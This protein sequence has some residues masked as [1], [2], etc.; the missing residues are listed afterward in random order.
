MEEILTHI[1]E[2]L[3]VPEFLINQ[4]NFLPENVKN[5]LITILLFPVSKTLYFITPTPS[6]VHCLLPSLYQTAVFYA[7]LFFQLRYRKKYGNIF[8]SSTWETDAL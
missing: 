6:S 2:V 7:L 1:Q 5:S 3:G 8:L 4:C